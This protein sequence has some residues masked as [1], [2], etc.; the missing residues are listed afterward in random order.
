MASITFPHAIEKL[1]GPNYA[2]WAYEMESVLR[3]EGLWAVTQ[4]N[5]PQ[6][7]A[8]TLGDGATNYDL[9]KAVQACRERE[10]KALAIIKFNT[11]YTLSHHFPEKATAAEAWTALAKAYRVPGVIKALALF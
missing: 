6:P 10:D 4:N 7:D 11:D 8:A 9:Y 5:D 2:K 3:Y 1:G